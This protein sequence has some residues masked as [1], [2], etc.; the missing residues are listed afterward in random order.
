VTP[1]TRTRSGRSAAAGGLLLYLR[2]SKTD[3]EARG[4]A[5]GIAHGR[6]AL[7]DPIAALGRLARPPRHRARTALFTSLRGGRPSL[8][9][10]AG[11]AVSNILKER[12]LTAGPSNGRISARSLRAGHGTSAAIAGIGI[13]R[14]AAQTRQRRIDILIERYIRPI[15]AL[16]TNSSRDSDTLNQPR[17]LTAPVR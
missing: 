12:A 5:I 4:Q 8:L 13:D 11:N 7:T 6:H 14:I 17:G 2:R 16:Q 15:P 1:S 10:I 9:P 3:Q